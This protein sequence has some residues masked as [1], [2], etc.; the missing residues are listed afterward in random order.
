MKSET[1]TKLTSFEILSRNS[2]ENWE[3]QWNWKP[4]WFFSRNSS[5][6]TV[7]FQVLVW[8]L[9]KTSQSTDKREI[10]TVISNRNYHCVWFFSET[11]WDYVTQFIAGAIHYL[12]LVLILMARRR[13]K[14]YTDGKIETIYHNLKT[15][16]TRLKLVFETIW[17]SPVNINFN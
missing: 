8:Q 7:E 9:G 11:F 14:H 3:K 16:L 13:G 15:W 10:L 2:S 1:A 12:F 6:C 4:L 5:A 17:N